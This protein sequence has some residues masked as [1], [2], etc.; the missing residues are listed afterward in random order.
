MAKEMAFALD[1]SKGSLKTLVENA[2]I[3]E[4]EKKNGKIGAS[5]RPIL[6]ANAEKI[7]ELTHAELQ[8]VKG[9]ITAEDTPETIAARVAKNVDTKLRAAYNTTQLTDPLRL[10]V[11]GMKMGTMVLQEGMGEKY[12]TSVSDKLKTEITA[13]LNANIT[14]FAALKPKPP[15]AAKQEP[16]V[17]QTPP[18]PVVTPTAPVVAEAPP[19]AAAP[20]AEPP[21]PAPPA[22]KA[23]PGV[24]ATVVAALNPI[25]SAAAAEPPPAPAQRKPEAAPPP[26]QSAPPAPPKD[27]ATGEPRRLIPDTE[28]APAAP[29]APPASTTPAPTSVPSLSSIFTMLSST[30]GADS[31]Q[32]D[33]AITL[34]QNV[35][36]QPNTPGE[37]VNEK[38]EGYI[39][40]A[41]TASGK[42]AKDFSDDDIKAFAT[43]IK[44][45]SHEWL[46]KNQTELKR[47]NL[48]AG[49]IR[50][51]STK[52]AM[53][54]RVRMTPEKV[55]AFASTEM[56]IIDK[57]DII[58][59]VDAQGNPTRPFDM[60]IQSMAEAAITSAAGDEAA[61]KRYKEQVAYEESHRAFYAS[62]EAQNGVTA[63]MATEAAR[64]RMRGKYSGNTQAAVEQMTSHAFQPSSWFSKII[65]YFMAFIGA[66]FGGNL[67][68][69]MVSFQDGSF[70]AHRRE[71]EASG[72]NFKL[73]N[74]IMSSSP[75]MLGYEGDEAGFAQWKQEL[76]TDVTGIH[77]DA[78]RRTYTDIN[79]STGA[80][81]GIAAISQGL[82]PDGMSRVPGME[83][84]MGGRH[85]YIERSQTPPQRTGSRERGGATPIGYDGDELPTGGD[86][87]ASYSPRGYNGEPIPAP[88]TPYVAP[89][90]TAGRSAGGGGYSGTP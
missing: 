22:P 15:A 71:K 44:E 29:A 79:R 82:T 84:V 36:S 19:T 10:A 45:A 73:Y 75:Q 25:S 53:G 17:A 85:L 18:P 11:D 64:H 61:K 69:L 23:A 60:N 87:T 63:G 83:D 48:S 72:K 16:V 51:L 37:G 24:I 34:M 35:L 40:G 47:G 33:A 88:A 90:P 5:V 8:A 2:M 74:K 66:L 20:A 80:T 42:D 56:F 13:N 38:I 65:D 59:G 46:N 78:S 6:S 41:I 86:R 21:P 76:A 68:Q 54:V 27:K 49:R 14:Q 32:R 62:E 26:T 77:F 67:G 58:T 89:R 4:Y 50:E 12:F 57:R 31:G 81:T 70:S 1:A 30:V 39:R 28:T 7:A 52:L 55:G 3:A 9:K 43:Q